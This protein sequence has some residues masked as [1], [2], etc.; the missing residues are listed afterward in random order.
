MAIH[1]NGKSTSDA[2]YNWFLICAY[3]CARATFLYFLHLAVWDCFLKTNHNRKFIVNNM[4]ALQV[5]HIVCKDELP[6]TKKPVVLSQLVSLQPLAEQPWPSF[7]YKPDV[8]FSIAHTGDHIVLTF[9]VD[10]AEVRH[11]NTAVNSSVWEDSCVEFFISFDDRGYYNFEFNCIGTALVGFGN[12][13]N[14]RK[15]LPE[16]LVKRIK[17]FAS[18]E[19]KADGF[20]W[21]L[22]AIIPLSVFMYH[23]VFNLE[24]KKCKANFY[25][26]GDKLSQPHFLAWNNIETAEP[27]FHQPAFFGEIE[28]EAKVS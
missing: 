22:Q 17:C 23:A 28:F 2:L 15:L 20:H 18:M 1:I 16:T 21:Q 14:N 5:P 11:V 27:D 24:G 13:R 25:K 7:A 3:G 26:C 6:S 9:D 8:K 19:K 4:R 10:E 12:D